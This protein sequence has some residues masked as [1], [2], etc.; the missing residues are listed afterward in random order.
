MKENGRIL[1]YQKQKKVKNQLK[2]PLPN[3]IEIAKTW[4]SELDKT[5]GFRYNFNNLK[6][7]NYF[8]HLKLSYKVTCHGQYCRPIASHIVS[9]SKTKHEFIVPFCAYYILSVNKM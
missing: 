7:E 2:G 8:V 1:K 9:M 5:N 3:R 4:E 6:C